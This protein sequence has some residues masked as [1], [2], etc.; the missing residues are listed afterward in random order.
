V[1]LTVFEQGIAVFLSIIFEKMPPT[2]SVP[3]DK[4]TTS[5]RTI[6]SNPPYI[7]PL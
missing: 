6:P 4:G 1:Y 7:I 5:I 2:I 3:R